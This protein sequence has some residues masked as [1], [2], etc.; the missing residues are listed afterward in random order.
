[1]TSPC[2]QPPSPTLRAA[3]RQFNDGDYFVCHETLEELWLDAQEPLRS[4][5][6]GVLQI[7]VGL[8]HLE[9]GNENGART[10]LER[11]SQL[12]APL[13]PRC[14]HLELDALLVQVREVRVLLDDP[15]Q[16]RPLSLAGRRPRITLAEAPD[17]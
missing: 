12:I 8:L 6:Q 11:G 17:A 10:L 13:A 2:T 5:Y 1:M 14:L 4:L 16:P 7:G 9:R 3:V 15:N